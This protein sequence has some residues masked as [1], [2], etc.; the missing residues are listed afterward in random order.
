MDFV[1]GI[2]DNIITIAAAIA[3]IGLILKYLKTPV[4]NWLGLGATPD[5]VYVLVLEIHTAMMLLLA[6]LSEEEN[7]SEEEIQDAIATLQ[8]AGIVEDD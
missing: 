6:A 8:R 1:R 5:D 7:P 3:A 4:L 2:G